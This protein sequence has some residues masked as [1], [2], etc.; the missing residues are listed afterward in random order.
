MQARIA[1]LPPLPQEVYEHEDESSEA[2]DSIG[3]L[4]SIGASQMQVFVRI[5]IQPEMSRSFLGDRLWR[6]REYA[7]TLAYAKYAGPQ[8]RDEDA[9]LIPIFHQYPLP[10]ILSKQP[11]SLYRHPD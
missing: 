10:A 3:S 11:K 8:T 6:H 7:P 4:P 2:S 9:N 1:K 5:R